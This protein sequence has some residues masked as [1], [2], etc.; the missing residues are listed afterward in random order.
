[1]TV[2]EKIVSFILVDGVTAAATIL[3][4]RTEGLLL[5][6]EDKVKRHQTRDGCAQYVEIGKNRR[7]FSQQPSN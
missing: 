3:C 5:S 4:K 2:K 1:M 6:V 7:C